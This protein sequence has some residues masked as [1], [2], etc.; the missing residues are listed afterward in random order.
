LIRDV[1]F[2]LWWWGMAARDEGGLGYQQGKRNIARFERFDAS[3]VAPE[4]GKK[5]RPE[6]RARECLPAPESSTN[7]SRDG[8]SG[9]SI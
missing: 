5:R 2:F 1:V 3:T 4:G 6:K 8:S 9:D 7:S